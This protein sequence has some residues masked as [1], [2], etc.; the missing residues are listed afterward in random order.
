[1][2]L[3]VQHHCLD[4]VNV[5]KCFLSFYKEINMTLP[6]LLFQFGIAATFSIVNIFQVSVLY[7]LKRLSHYKS[8]ITV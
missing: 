7:I 4:F 8:C 3:I 5:N 1:M 2:W 6:C